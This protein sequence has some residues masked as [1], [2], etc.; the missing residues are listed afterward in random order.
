MAVT[1]H[2]I[3]ENFENVNFILD[4]VEVQI[5]HSG[6]N[7]ALHLVKTFREFDILHKVLSI[8]HRR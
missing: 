3:D 2:Y 8:L 4:F 5:P 1:I 6:M 7:I